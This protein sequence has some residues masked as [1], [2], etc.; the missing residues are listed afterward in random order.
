[1][2]SKIKKFLIPGLIFLSVIV[3][4]VLP[5]GPSNFL[6]AKK[7]VR[8]L[9]KDQPYTFYC[10][11]EYNSKGFLNTQSCGYKAQKKWERAERIEIEHIMPAH[12]FGKNLPCW[13]KKDC[14]S[15][16][17]KKIKGRKCCQAIDARFNQMEADLYNLVPA[18]G[19]VNYTR[20]NYK[21][22]EL[23]H[24]QVG[25]FGDC[26][27]KVDFQKKLVEPDSKLKGWIARAYLYMSDTYAL[28]LSDKEKQQFL[29]WHE[30]YP[31]NRIEIDWAQEIF[32]ITRN[33]NHYIL[34]GIK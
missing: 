19:E 34:N 30:A 11:C 2:A 1:M 8:Q 10:G 13:R 17:G 6:E 14:L 21:F 29:T 23:S 9:F 28:K 3:A 25:L 4:N 33:K 27:F 24:I 5:R 15:T 31:P 26:Y 22:A 32:R 7:I 16:Q 12:T 20:S 18:I